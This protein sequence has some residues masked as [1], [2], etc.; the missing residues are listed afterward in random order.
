[1]VTEVGDHSDRVVYTEKINCGGFQ[2]TA[3]TF[4]NYEGHFLWESLESAS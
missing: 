4:P 2:K 3:V 1:M